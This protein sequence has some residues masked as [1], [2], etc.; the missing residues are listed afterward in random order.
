MIYYGNSGMDCGGAVT[1]SGG[2]HFTCQ[3]L[4]DYIRNRINSQAKFFILPIGSNSYWGVYVPPTNFPNLTITELYLYD[5]YN[6]GS[7]CAVNFNNTTPTAVGGKRYII[8]NGNVESNSNVT[9]NVITISSRKYNYYQYSSAQDYIFYTDITGYRLWYN[10]NP[11]INY[12]WQC[13]DAIRGEFGEIPLAQIKPEKINNAE[14]VDNADSSFFSAL[15]ENA[16]IEVIGSGGTTL[17]PNRYYIETNGEE[18]GTEL[19]EVY[20]RMLVY[21]YENGGA[22]FEFYGY[23]ENTALVYSDFNTHDAWL[24]VLVDHENEAAQALFIWF[25]SLTGYYRY[26][27]PSTSHTYSDYQA[28]YKILALS[29]PVDGN[30]INED[31]GEPG[32]WTPRIDKPIEAP[33]IPGKSAI[34]TGF[35]TMYKVD[36][37]DLQTLSAFLWSD[38]FI[39]IIKKFFDD[40]AQA[41]IGLSIFPVS[42][43][44]AGTKTNIKPGGV[45]TDAQGY[46]LN[47]QYRDI[48]MGSK[49]IKPAGNSFLDFHPFTKCKI[50]LPYCGIH[51]LD[52][53]DIMGKTINLH[54]VID[55]LTG[56][57]V[58][59][60]LV[61]GS[62]HYSF[63][64]TANMPVP[65]SKSSYDQ[66]VSSVISTGVGV[67]TLLVTSATGGLASVAP[68]GAL[69]ASGLNSMNIHPN[70]DYSSGGGGGNGLIGC[71]IPFLIYEEPIP[72]L[73]QYQSSYLGRPTFARHKLNDLSGFTQCLDA[74]LINMTCTQEEQNE[75]LSYLKNG[76]LIESGSSTP[77]LSPSAGNSMFRF[78]KNK[79]E[80]N[81]I[82]KTWSNSY[83]DVEGSLLFN[84]SISAPQLTITGDIRGYNY[85]YAPIFNRFY[86]VDDIRIDTGNLQTVSLKVDALQSFKS[87]IL[88]CYAVVQRQKTKTNKYFNDP[89]YWTQ[90]NKSIKT[91]PFDDIF[92]RSDNCYVL[93]IAGDS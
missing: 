49:Y 55:F 9:L 87:E 75:I 34:S 42:P 48:D 58:A 43:N 27:S 78:L 65:I 40:P 7:V 50:F 56:S 68:I 63:S 29:A 62:L 17:M 5:T 41:I 1:K 64:G 36:D 77:S 52:L 11:I 73:A 8:R 44:T 60:I 12:N 57:C 46:K 88:D 47:S 70:I 32:D 51:D 76:V 33:V 92:E 30:E 24:Y 26:N 67:G 28:L 37:G 18:P 25:D 45:Q 84:Q 21:N 85:V 74:H 23:L 59:Y 20:R 80:N 71:Q 86:Y 54:Y 69:T 79:S 53:N 93:V 2:A 38:A 90:L 6:S 4:L 91:D 31:T 61:N 35:T 83:L 15:P 81:V 66:I 19:F 72:K 82:G 16:K 22:H 3:E 89:E 10:D 14:Y 13:L 39:D